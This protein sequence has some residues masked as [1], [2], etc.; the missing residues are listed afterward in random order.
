MTAPFASQLLKSIG[1]K[2]KNNLNSQ[3]ENNKELAFKTRH[4]QQFLKHHL[5]ESGI[6]GGPRLAHPVPIG[7]GLMSA[8]TGH[9]FLLLVRLFKV[10]RVLGPELLVERARNEAAFKEDNDPLVVAF[11]YL[12][13]EVEVPSLELLVV[14]GLHVE[15]GPLQ[16]LLKH[17]DLVNPKS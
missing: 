4:T 5:V 1:F 3:K 11:H 8:A 13:V 14:Q 9:V 7:A 10:A 12:V 2:G 16:L 17:V 6:E 15:V